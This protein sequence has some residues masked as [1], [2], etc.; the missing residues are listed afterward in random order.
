MKLR[1]LICYRLDDRRRH[2]PNS[3][4]LG[5]PS[6]FAICAGLLFV[7]TK[8]LRLFSKSKYKAFKVYESHRG[9]ILFS[10]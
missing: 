3:K 9:Y 2:C 7:V 10:G 1:K 5:Y 8:N 4:F 6:D